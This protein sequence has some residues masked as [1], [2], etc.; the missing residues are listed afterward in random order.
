M[1][2]WP[3]SPAR[4]DAGRISTEPG[5]GGART[6]SLEGEIPL[7]YSSQLFNVVFHN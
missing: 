2:F 5:H 6:L 7:Q 4:I 1:L 3:R